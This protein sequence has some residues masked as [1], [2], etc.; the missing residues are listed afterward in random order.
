MLDT[1]FAVALGVVYAMVV[2]QSSYALF[3]LIAVSVFSV[4]LFFVDFV[5]LTHKSLAHIAIAILL[6]VWIALLSLYTL[7]QNRLPNRYYYHPLVMTATVQSVIQV[8]P[9]VQRLTVLTHVVDHQ[10]ISQKILLNI[11]QHAMPIQANDVWQLK[12]KLK[13]PRGLNNFTGNNYAKNALVQHIVAT[14]YVVNDASNQ[15]LQRADKPVSACIQDF[16]TGSNLPDTSKKLLLSLLLGNRELLTTSDWEVLQNTGTSHLVAI[17]GLHIG[18]LGVLGFL[19]FNYG[20]RLFPSLLLR[21]PAQRFGAM[22]SLLFA[23]VYTA[24]T[25][26]SLSAMRAFIMLALALCFELIDS[27]LPL[28][29]RL[30]FAVSLIVIV[31]PLAV[32]SLSL[33][34]SV[35]AVSLIVYVMQTTQTVQPSFSHKLNLWFRLQLAFL[36]GTAGVT[37]LVFQTVSLVSPLANFIAVPMISWLILPL[38]LFSIACLTCHLS[39]LA[40]WILWLASEL[41]EKLW[42]Y[43][44]TLSHWHFAAWHAGLSHSGLMLLPIA[45]IAVLLAPPGWRNRLVAGLLLLPLLVEAKSRPNFGHFKLTVLDVGQ[46]LASVIQTQHHAMVYDTGPQFVSGFDAGQKVVMPYLYQQS[47]NPVDLLM[48]SHGDND[49]IGGVSYVLAHRLVDEAY[50]SI[51]QKLGVFYAKYCHEGQHWLWDGVSF[52]VLSPA[53]GAPYA[54]NNSSCVLKVNSSFGSALLVGDIEKP[55][56]A[57]LLAHH[58]LKLKS[59]ILIAPHHGSKT[60][61][62]EDFV[63][64]IKPALVIFA[65]GDHNRYRFPDKNVKLRYQKI[66]AKTLNTAKVGAIE[67]ST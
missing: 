5:W 23:F 59:D 35:L 54:D 57:W 58:S 56:E 20:A 17:S 45:F 43:L 22:A 6:G 15:K 52:E 39:T 28:A 4:L 7:L 60:S 21:I 47:I 36:F 29:K 63:N 65:T 8:N 62:S 51:P 48:V 3:F 12:V 49:H 14:G 27:T 25:G 19:L 13:P 46:G 61:S 33:W 41:I 1:I 40:Y 42:R 66:G 64:H 38:A 53:F 30:L 11:Y 44:Q 24:L 32:W 2:L 37:L 26:F 34:L 50:S 10:K 16:V 67:I 31:D 9:F 18:M 55:T